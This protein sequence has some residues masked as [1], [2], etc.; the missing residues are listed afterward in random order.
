MQCGHRVGNA[1]TLGK[2]A[3]QG[4]Q[5]AG[6]GHRFHALGSTG[7]ENFFS[8]EDNAFNNRPVIL[9]VEHI[10]DKVTAYFD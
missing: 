3:T 4:Q 7:R 2:V 9:T 8:Q 5:G 6:M 1:V 10:A